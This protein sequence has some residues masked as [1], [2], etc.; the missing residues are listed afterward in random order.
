M[1]KQNKAPITAFIGGL[2]GLMTF[3]VINPDYALIGLIVG[4]LIGYALGKSN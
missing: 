1:V 4:L 3:G 2:V